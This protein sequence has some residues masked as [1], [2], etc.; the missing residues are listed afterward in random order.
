MSTQV[1]A[2]VKVCGLQ[3][4]EHFSSAE[5]KPPDTYSPEQL[6]RMSYVTIS[7]AVYLQPVFN[8]R[9]KPGTMH[10]LNNSNL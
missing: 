6:I 10:K 1:A 3:K 8:P 5:K 9:D 7:G 2:G 4:A